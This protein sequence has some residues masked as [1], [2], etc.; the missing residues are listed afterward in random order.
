MIF[1]MFWPCKPL[2]MIAANYILT[3]ADLKNTGEIFGILNMIIRKVRYSPGCIQADLWQNAEKNSFMVFEIWSSRDDF[4]RY[5]NTS[6]YK[7]FLTAMELSAEPPLIN[8]SEC[9]K[10]RGIDMIEEMMVPSSVY[11]KGTK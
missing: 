8:I 9:E 7:Q 5:V 10:V 2:M 6:T 11:R 1:V 4:R 3:C